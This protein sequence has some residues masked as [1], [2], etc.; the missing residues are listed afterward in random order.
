M[1]LESDNE[2]DIEMSVDNTKNKK[3]NKHKRAKLEGESGLY[4]EVCCG[5]VL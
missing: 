5:T 2:S 3:K 4:H 1:M